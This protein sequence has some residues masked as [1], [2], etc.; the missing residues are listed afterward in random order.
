VKR[1]S[2][3]GVSA[4]VVWITFSTPL[5][6][7]RSLR[8]IKYYQSSATAEMLFIPRSCFSRLV[9]QLLLDAGD[10]KVHY[11]I[12]RDAMLAL[13]TMTEHVLVMFFE[14][15]QQLAIHAKRQTIMKSDMELLQDIIFTVDP[16]NGLGQKCQRKVQQ[17]EALKNDANGK[18]D[19]KLK[20]ATRRA[21]EL[22]AKGQPVPKWLRHYLNEGGD[23]LRRSYRIE[24]AG[25]F[26][27][28]VGNKF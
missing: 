21:R 4:L 9:Q 19:K 28:A 3:L 15:T 14:M 23:G 18:C 26:G 5:T 17:F 25:S 10:P 2:S 1:T 22:E 20:E 16:N 24:R 7:A 13:Q 12:E 6:L 27:A 11:R 8:E